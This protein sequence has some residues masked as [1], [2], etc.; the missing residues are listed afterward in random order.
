MKLI[1]KKF[2]MSTIAALALAAACLTASTQIV[3]AD[4]VGNVNTEV[5]SDVKDNRQVLVDFLT[6]KGIDEE[7][8]ELYLDLSEEQDFSKL[9]EK[10]KSKADDE[11]KSEVEE[12]L[13]QFAPQQVYF[14]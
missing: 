14:N 11:I 8:A 9:L 5:R 7:D 2:A 3:N 6:Q 13:N 4:Q 10:L 1:C 12:F